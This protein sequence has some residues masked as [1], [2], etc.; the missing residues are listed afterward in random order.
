MSIT[1]EEVIWW[2]CGIER[3]G[4]IVMQGIPWEIFVNRPVQWLGRKTFCH[5]QGQRI[6]H[7]LCS[8]RI[9]YRMTGTR[10]CMR[11]AIDRPRTDKRTFLVNHINFVIT[12]DIYLCRLPVEGD[13]RITANG[14]CINQ[15]PFPMVIYQPFWKCSLSHCPVHWI[16]TDI[17]VVLAELPI[18]T[19]SAVRWDSDILQVHRHNIRIIVVHTPHSDNSRLSSFHR[20]YQCG[21]DVCISDY[22]IVLVRHNFHWHIHPVALMQIICRK[23]SQGIVIDQGR[24][25]SVFFI[26]SMNQ[27]D[28]LSIIQSD[29]CYGTER[30]AMLTHHHVEVHSQ[31]L[32]EPNLFAIVDIQLCTFISGTLV[33]IEIQSIVRIL[34]QWRGINRQRDRSHYYTI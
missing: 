26:S 11:T 21:V 29:M 5:A 31:I 18:K 24:T 3:T 28:N 13:V 10:C 19:L 27:S 33:G 30:N 2:I 20:Y 6:E 8:Y 12:G 4:M 16:K 1:T 32:F 14:I 15:A 7:K 25:N 34:R 22:Y 9:I 23:V 17:I